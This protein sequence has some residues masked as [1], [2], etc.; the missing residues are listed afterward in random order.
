MGVGGSSVM[1]MTRVP[2]SVAKNFVHSSTGAD[3]G[4]CGFGELA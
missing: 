2:V 1:S 3:Q 4:Y